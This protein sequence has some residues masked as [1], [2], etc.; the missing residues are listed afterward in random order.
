[1]AETQKDKTLKQKMSKH[2]IWQKD[3]KKVASV[4]ISPRQQE[5]DGDP[6]IGLVAAWGR[7]GRWDMYW[8][9]CSSRTDDV[10][11]GLSPVGHLLSWASP[12]GLIC[13][14]ADGSEWGCWWVSEDTSAWVTCHFQFDSGSDRNL[15]MG[16]FGGGGEGKGR[17]QA[18]VSDGM[19]RA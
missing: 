18:S 7:W 14:Q 2:E 8:Q 9:M 16:G 12:I 13:N 1:M 5:S 11:C 3:K 17:P 15:H 19:C 4:W 6:Q 10:F